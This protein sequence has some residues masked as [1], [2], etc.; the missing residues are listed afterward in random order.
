M[1]ERKENKFFGD[2]FPSQWSAFIFI[3]YMILFINQGIYRY[4]DL[5][6]LLIIII[7]YYLTIF[8]NQS[9]V[10]FVIDLVYE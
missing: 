1:T 10:Y 5:N 3:S 9:Y 2:L 7:K 6:F 8:I 4:I